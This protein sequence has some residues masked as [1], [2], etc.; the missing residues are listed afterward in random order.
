MNEN[1]SND[2]EPEDASQNSNKHPLFY[3]N[4]DSLPLS[5]TNISKMLNF[6]LDRSKSNESIN[7]EIQQIKNMYDTDLKSFKKY[8]VIGKAPIWPGGYLLEDSVS[9][10]GCENS[11][12]GSNL[13]FL[14][15]ERNR[16]LDCKLEQSSSLNSYGSIM[17]LN[18]ESP[19]EIANYV[20]KV[21]NFM[22]SLKYNFTGLQFY[23]INKS[24]SIRS[25]MEI[26]KQ[27]I[28]CSLPI[29]CL[30]A[31]ILGIHLTNGCPSSL[32]RFT[33]SFKSV[34]KKSK[35]KHYHVLLGL[36]IKNVGYGTI[37][38]SRK[39]ELAYKKLGNFETLEK[40]I[41]N[42]KSSYETCGHVLKRVS[43]GLPISHNTCSLESLDWTCV[44]V[45][46]GKLKSVD[47]LRVRTE[48]FSRLLRITVKDS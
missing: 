41:F 4:R 6:C 42:I 32:V 2:L 8:P 34:C 25:L 3:I 38:M 23:D 24:R 43:F 10:F 18:S 35:S 31:V 5:D 21:Q 27:M 11:G 22:K 13:N 16:S 17:S 7:S 19:I 12:N 48:R 46:V 33:L 40:L 28:K 37:G 36:Y 44:V 15:L 9:Y 14:N 45:E 29:K 30:E 26:A 47:E 20:D 39:D 1:I